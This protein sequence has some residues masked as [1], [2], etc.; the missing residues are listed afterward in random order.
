[1][2]RTSILIGVAALALALTLPAAQGRQTA[3][4]GITGN[5]ILIG[6]TTP[7]SGVASAYASVARGAEAYFKYVNAHGGVNGR[8]INYKYLDDQYNPS[9][10]VQQTRQLVQQDRVFAIYNS[11][12]TEHNL[13]IRDYLN[14]VRVPQIFAA[15]G[16]RTFGRD[17]AKYPWTIGYQPS[18]YGESQIYGRWIAK[19]KPRAR[20]AVIYQNDDYGKEL[21]AGLRKGLGRMANRIVAT[22]GYEVTETDVQSQIARLKTSNANTFMIFATPRYAIQSFIYTN[23]LGWKPQ[24][25]VNSVSSA[26]NIM[27]IASDAGNNKR[28]QGT[29]AIQFLKDPTDSTRWVGDPGMKL[30]RQIM[31]RYLPR[32][33]ANDVFHVYAMASAHTFVQAL[34]KAGRNPTRSGVMAQLAKLNSKNPFAIPGVTIKTGRTDRFPVEQ[35]QLT[36]WSV[37][38]KGDGRWVR[39]GPLQRTPG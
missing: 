32:G 34:R 12:G 36:R 15:T 7:L 17:F 3:D 11:L 19:N 21:I 28:V 1:M 14:S 9:I 8:K 37:N 5:S 24:I 30:Y 20:I 35:V 26:S 2:K 25:F 27:E 31:K 23:R 6:G 4:P 29:I 39:F 13:A 33:N 16:A 18:Y 10:T 38:R 22:Q